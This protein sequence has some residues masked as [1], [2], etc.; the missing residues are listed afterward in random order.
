[1][2]KIRGETMSAKLTTAIAAIM[3]MGSATIAMADAGHHDGKK[4]AKPG[5]MGQMQQGNDDANMPMAGGAMMGG[6]HH[7]MMQTMMKMMMQMQ[8]QMHGGMMQGGMMQ[9]G[10]SP[11]T[12]NGMMDRDMMGMMSGAMMGSA[13]AD[14]DG[15]G[16]VSAE[17]AHEFMQFMHQ[18]AD[19]DGDGVVTLEEFESM[20]SMMMRDAMVDRFQHLDADGDGKITGSEMTAPADRMGQQMESAPMMKD[21][22]K[23]QDN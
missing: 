11:D 14:N 7:A 4:K 21:G 3:A 22:S 2:T 15:D 19:K 6:D 10:M 1:M 17:E 12:R 5:E 18:N 8:M 16:S 9:G 13:G 20:H 23:S